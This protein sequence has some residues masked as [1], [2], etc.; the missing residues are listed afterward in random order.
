MVEKN[1]KECDN[2]FNPSSTKTR[3]YCSVKCYRDARKK[4]Y[5][6]SVAAA[7]AKYPI[8]DRRVDSD[9]YARVRIGEYWISEHRFVMEQTLDRELLPGESVHHKNG[10]RCDNSVDNLELWLG[11]IRYGQRAVDVICP[12]CNKTYV[13]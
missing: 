9:G 10:I 2:A 12:H 8:S 7:K 13:L 11:G 1:C 5:K 6:S 3:L 4:R